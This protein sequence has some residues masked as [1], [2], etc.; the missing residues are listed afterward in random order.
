[1]IGLV[2]DGRTAVFLPATYPITPTRRYLL[3]PE[4]KTR[5]QEIHD[6]VEELVARGTSRPD[7]FK[8]LA[9]EYGLKT[10]SVRGAFYQ[11][12]PGAE[13]GRPRRTRRRETTPEDAFADAR[14]TLEEAIEAI[15]AEVAAAETRAIEAQAEFAA[16][17]A[18]SEGRK[19]EI[20]AK[21]AALQ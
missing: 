9:T 19:E 17:A 8:Q 18:A 13:N 6:K 14:R 4:Q 20:R 1:V 2:A 16:M 3:M 15:D 12:R 11:G 10:N 21:L 7:A 5:A